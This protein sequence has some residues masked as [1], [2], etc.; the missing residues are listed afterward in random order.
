MGVEGWVE[1]GFWVEVVGRTRLVGIDTEA[2]LLLVLSLQPRRRGEAIV[3]TGKM[4]GRWVAAHLPHCR[5]SLGKVTKVDQ[6]VVGRLLLHH[7]LGRV[8]GQEALRVVVRMG[9]GGL[10]I[11]L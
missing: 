11:G 3:I 10:E 6:V 8:L 4:L 7:L 1:G 9:R 2:E 5:D